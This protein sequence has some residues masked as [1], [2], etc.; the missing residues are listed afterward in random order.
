MNMK[1]IKHKL[2]ITMAVI[3]L[4]LLI[5]ACKK[6]LD[7]QPLG[8]AIEGDVVQGAVEQ[9]V[10][11]LYSAVRDWGMTQ[12]PYLMVHSVRSDDAD[13][14]S[15]V[16]DGADAEAMYDNFQYA[17]DFWMLEPY[18]N[19]HFAFINLSNNV[20]HIVDSLKLTDAPSLVNKAEARFFRAYAYFDLVRSFGSVPKI[21][22]K[23]YR[24]E[25]ANKPKASINEI[26]ALID[27]DLEFAIATLPPEWE[28]KFIGRATRGAANTLK[29]KADLFR[30]NWAG[31][32]ARTEDVIN[33]GKYELYTPY[34]RLFTEEAENSK[35]SIFEIQNYLSSNGTQEFSNY[36][37]QY[38]GV[39]GSGD[40]DLG[41]GWNAPNALLV[42]S[43]ETG[44]TR[45]D[46]TILYSGQSDGIYGQTVPASPPLARLYWNKKVYTDPVR[47]QQTGN[48]FSTWLNMPVYRYADVLL[49]A[50]EAAN[51]IG[52]SANTTKALTYLERVRARARGGNNSV[53]PPVT[54]TD[55]ALLRDAIRKERRSE[56]GMENERF[57]DLVRWGTAQTVLTNA[58]KPYLPRNR[59]LPIPQ[60]A[61]DRSGG[62]LIQNPDY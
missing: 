55:Q 19:D 46:A 34:T 56:L 41:W 28:P 52:G 22:F 62:V 29:A 15:T 7:R 16:T 47:R 4:T 21:D 1:S 44:D 60:S 33:S 51:E 32:L 37:A 18:W 27:A 30:Q 3:A 9:Q 54:T 20:I 39:R 6:F 10:F 24:A 58:G 5:S 8:S 11:G 42:N 35:E 26:Y 17:K 48:R 36:F 14:G 2:R 57:F 43:F 38:Q 12:L 40:W 31:A 59:Y 45:K 50:A 25:E 23:V 53:L 61:I 49:M 13:K